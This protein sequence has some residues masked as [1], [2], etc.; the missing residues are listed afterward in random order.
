M[1]EKDLKKLNR[2]EILEIM[3]QVSKENS[4]LHEEVEELEGKLS[5][6]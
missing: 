2:E 3:I 4:R 1:I 6:R 5:E